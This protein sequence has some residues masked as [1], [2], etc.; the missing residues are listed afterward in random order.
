MKRFLQGLGLGLVIA[1][2]AMGITMRKDESLAGESLVEKAREIGMVF[3][4]GSGRPDAFSED[5]SEDEASPEPTKSG[6]KGAGVGAEGDSGE[7]ESGE[8]A[9]SSKPETSEKPS[10]KPKVSETPKPTESPA[11]TTSP[12]PTES[13]EPTTSPA[14]TTTPEPTATPKPSKTP[15]PR[16]TSDPNATATPTHRELPDGTVVHFRVRSGLLSSSVAREM[17]EAGIIDDMW[18]FD[19]YIENHGLGARII[20]GTYDLTVGDSYRNLARIIT[21]GG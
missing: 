18:D 3:P 12:E 14:P 21:H 20:S 4:Q 10:E 1:A 17:Y 11:S 2:I 15:K 7:E 5:K 16:G 8:E 6:K 19:H 13:P 9:A